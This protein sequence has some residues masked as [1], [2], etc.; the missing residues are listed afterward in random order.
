MS[1]Y[2][3]IWQGG[4]GYTAS[5]GGDAE[6]IDSLDQARELMRDRLA[7]FG[8]FAYIYRDTDNTRTPGVDS[9]S[10]LYLF[11]GLSD[12]PLEDLRAYLDNSNGPDYLIRVGARGG[13]TTERG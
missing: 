3:G 12:M 13:I 4:C 8:R 6:W 5:D 10:G 11:A 7:G 2:V 9:E 1:K